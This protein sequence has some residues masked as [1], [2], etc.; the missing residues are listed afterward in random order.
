MNNKLLFVD[1]ERNVLSAYERNLR[2]SY[3]IVCST[4]ANEAVEIIRR[5]EEEKEPFAV[6]VSDYR[7]PEMD[8]NRFL[9]LARQIAPDSVRIMLTGYAE[10]NLAIEAVNEGSIFR[11]L[12]KPCPGDKLMNTLKSAIEQYRLIVSEKELLDKTLKGSIKVLVDILSIANPVAF[13]RA[14]NILKIA[15]R[16]SVQL[17]P[18]IQWQVEIA[19]LLSQ[20][21][22]IA[23][24]EEI[25]AKK[26]NGQTLN[27]KEKELYLAHPQVGKSLIKNIPRLEDI[28]EAISFQFKKFTALEYKGEQ[29]HEG[30]VATISR[31]LKHANDLNTLMEA[32]RSEAQ[33]IAELQTKYEVDIEAD[34]EK[35]KTEFE[36]NY[37]PRSLLLKRL[38]PGMI[39]RQDI[40][41]KNGLALV[42]QGQELSEALIHKLMSFAQLNRIIEPVQVYVPNSDAEQL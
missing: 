18:E 24:P 5:A 27:L 29:K 19:A 41:D 15:K 42:A 28:A 11:F 1:D 17:A 40:I 39:L 8:G 36:K 31:I 32:N 23:V 12:T 4:S 38:M 13:S 6:I 37:V 14:G 35:E 10:V 2:L 3:E 21:G 22:C 20:I 7:M 30:N 25:L 16:L 9:S 26:R 33:A 34:L